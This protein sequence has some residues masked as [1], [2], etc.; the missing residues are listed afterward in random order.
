VV[1]A[2][3]AAATVLLDPIPSL[4]DSIQAPQQGG[5]LVDGKS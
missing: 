5:S 1:L 3:A 4:S 2:L